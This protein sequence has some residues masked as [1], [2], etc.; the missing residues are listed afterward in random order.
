M[1]V[2]ME[3]LED[4]AWGLLVHQYLITIDNSIT[5]ARKE[6]TEMAPVA[7]DKIVDSEGQ[8]AG[9]DWGAVAVGLGEGTVFERA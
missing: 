9:L 8:A 5:W 4:Q 6:A 7:S 3:Y 1:G 2:I